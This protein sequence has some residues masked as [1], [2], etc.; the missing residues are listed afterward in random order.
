MLR[1]RLTSDPP[2]TSVAGTKE[3]LIKYICVV[4]RREGIVLCLW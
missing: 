1:S 4:T 3:W 2:Y